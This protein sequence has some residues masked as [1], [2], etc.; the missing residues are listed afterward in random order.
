MSVTGSYCSW[1]N[2]FGFM[3]VEKHSIVKSRILHLDVDISTL[4][5]L[6]SV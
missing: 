2:P 4:Y 6:F 5:G 1:D 3:S